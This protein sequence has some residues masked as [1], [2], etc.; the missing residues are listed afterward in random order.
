MIILT[1]FQSYRI[2]VSQLVVGAH[3]HFQAEAEWSSDYNNPLWQDKKPAIPTT[4][5]VCI[6]SVHIP[7]GVVLLY[8]PSSGTLRTGTSSC[9][10][11]AR[12][13][14]NAIAVSDFTIATRKW[15]NLYKHRIRLSVTR[16]EKCFT[17]TL[18][19]GSLLRSVCALPLEVSQRVS[20]ANRFKLLPISRGCIDN[21]HVRD[22]HMHVVR[23][24][25][26]A[27]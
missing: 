6:I 19:K 26:L 7:L 18:Q 21:F 3:C 16:S 15:A 24:H 25:V 14:T 4:K 5:M 17:F 20:P 22:N 11:A 9:A 1:Y 23:S 8:I 12:Y 13:H 27:T 2:E 10:R